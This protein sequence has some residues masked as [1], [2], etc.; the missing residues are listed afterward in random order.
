[1]SSLICCHC[2][3]A[4]N[5]E[6]LLPD[7]QKRNYEAKGCTSFLFVLIFFLF[8]VKSHI[9]LLLSKRASGSNS[10]YPKW[11]KMSWGRKACH[12]WLSPSPLPAFLPWFSSLFQAWT[13]EGPFPWKQRLASDFQ[14]SWLFASWVSIHFQFYVL[15]TGSISCLRKNTQKGHSSNN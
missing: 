5:I 11:T 8:W 10:P 3:T 15:A 9:S 6:L 7:P 12:A 13:C 1:M 4:H 14:G 2:R